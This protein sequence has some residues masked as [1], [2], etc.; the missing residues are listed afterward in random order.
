M[1]ELDYPDLRSVPAQRR[2][3]D[4]PLLRRM[5]DAVSFDYIWVCGLDLPGF[6][7]GT[8]RS[9]DT[10][11]PPLFVEKYIAANFNERDPLVLSAYRERRPLSDL[12][13]YKQFGSPSGLQSLLADFRIFGRAIIPVER[14]GVSFGAVIVARTS[15]FLPDELDYLA[16][17]APPLHDRVTKS[18]MARYGADF[19][20]LSATEMRCLALCEQGLTSEQ[21]AV[22]CGLLPQTINGYFLAAAK[23]LGATN[24]VQTVAMAIRRGLI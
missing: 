19:L 10:D 22:E 12:E 7:A 5:R 16:L 18:I 3:N 17:V 23:K 21:I 13:A 6:E 2:L 24:R 15:A 4:E 1:H 20:R 11:F 8:A 14:H 9:V